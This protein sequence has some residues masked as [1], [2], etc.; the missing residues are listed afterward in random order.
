MELCDLHICGNMAY[1]SQWN[2]SITCCHEYIGVLTAQGCEGRFQI[3]L[4]G[5]KSILTCLRHIFE[6]ASLDLVV[7]LGKRDTICKLM[8][9]QKSDHT[10]HCQRQ[11]H[12]TLFWWDCE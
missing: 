7:Q 3:R 10:T 4:F 11:L 9:F 5:C 12:T 2:T 6:H 1:M 8:L